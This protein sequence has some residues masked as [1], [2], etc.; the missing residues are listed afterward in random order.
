MWKKVEKLSV[1][2]QSSEHG[3]CT[4]QLTTKANCPSCEAEA[5][6]VLAKTVD[7]FLTP[8]A[9]SGLDDLAGFY[10]CKTASCPVIYF[11]KDEKLTQKDLTVTVGLKDGATPDTLCYCFEW[12]ETAIKL[13][14]EEKGES[15]ASEDISEKMASLGCSCEIL[16]PSGRCCLQ[17]I[18]KTIKT[19]KT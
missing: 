8:E 18:D 14:L 17:D 19:L 4:P 7:C 9:K 13:E 11:K 5:K 1:H 10:Y 12:T 2:P 16:N 15:R 3:C 6:S